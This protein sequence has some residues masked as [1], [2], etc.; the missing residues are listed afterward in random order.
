LRG[1]YP[2]TIS[3]MSTDRLTSRTVSSAISATHP[4]RADK[5]DTHLAPEVKRNEPIC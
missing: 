4:S 2:E 3:C 1:I 5:K